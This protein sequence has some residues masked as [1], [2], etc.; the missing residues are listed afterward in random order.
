[1]SNEAVVI[2]IVPAIND[3]G[4]KMLLS[5]IVED[6]VFIPLETTEKCLIGRIRS[7]HC[8]NDY[9]IIIDADPNQ[10][11]LFDKAGKFIRTIG[12]KG[13][14]PGEY[15]YPFWAA[16]IND[17]LFIWDL[18]LN[19][20]FCYDL[21]TGKCLRIKAHEATPCSM[22]CFND[23]V[24]VYYYSF[25]RGEDPKKFTHIRTLSLNFEVANEF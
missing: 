12:S 25:P 22:D 8:S 1:M 15:I 21:R 24:L 11:L 10:I 6:I 4:T 2:N 19:K 18:M 14:G 16:L 9:I 17:E 5:E 13:Q 7:I 3:E 23:S 20:T